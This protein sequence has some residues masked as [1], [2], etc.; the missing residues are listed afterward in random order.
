[1]NSTWCHEDWSIQKTYVTAECWTSRHM[2]PWWTTAWF[3]MDWC[4]LQ[5]AGFQCP[6]EYFCSN[7]EWHVICLT[8]FNIMTIIDG[9]MIYR[10]FHITAYWRTCFR[11]D[12][13]MRNLRTD[14]DLRSLSG[15]LSNRTVHANGHLV[16]LRLQSEL[17]EVRHVINI[18]PTPTI[19]TPEKS[20]TRL[21]WIWKWYGLQQKAARL[22]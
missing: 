1:M 13:V 15:L 16:M 12:I 11:T 21:L 7:I 19:V 3:Q 18:L 17:E 8:L 4:H 20:L 9:Y 10:I 5:E 14:V 6:L 22:Y 2:V